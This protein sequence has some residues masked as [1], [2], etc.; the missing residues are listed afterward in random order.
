MHMAAKAFHARGQKLTLL[1]VCHRTFR[2]SVP[3]P[4]SPEA[5]AAQPL[6]MKP[7]ASSTHHHPPVI[8]HDVAYVK[9]EHKLK[10][11][12]NRIAELMNEKESLEHVNIQLQEE[13]ETVGESPFHSQIVKLFPLRFR[14]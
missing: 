6:N 14:D 8:G 7:S 13:T 3:P 9:M 12:M 4:L 11:A 2:F 1:R 5:T 10:D